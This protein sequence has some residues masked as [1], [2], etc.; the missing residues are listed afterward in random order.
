[1]SDAGIGVLGLVVLFGLIMIRIPV[2]IGLILVGVGGYALVDGWHVATIVAGEVPYELAAG[3]SLSV[4]PLFVLMGAVAARSNMAQELFDSAHALFSG[5]RGGLAMATVGACAAFGSICGSS[6]ATAA[7][8]TRVS[9]PEMLRHAYAN[10]LATG[11][12]VAGGTL[13]ILIPPSVILVIY[14]VIAEESVAALFAAALIPGLLLAAFQVLVVSAWCRIDRNVAPQ[15]DRLPWLARLRALGRAWK[16]LLLF[17]LSVG[18]IYLGLFSPTE[19]AAVGAGGAILIA[20]ATRAIDREGLV[21]AF[22]ETVTTTAMLFFIILGAT[23]FGRFIVL[24]QLPAA[25]T[26][27]VE[28]LALSPMLVIVVM[29][30]FYFLLGCFLESIS[31]LLITVPVFLP[32]AVAIGYDPVWF[33]VLVVIVVEVG[34]MT[35]PVGM[36]LFVVRAQMPDIPLSALYVGVMPFL[37]ANI[38]LI[39]VLLALPDVALWLPALLY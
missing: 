2:A 12:V 36:N 27:W 4:V 11:S 1:M 28:G 23:L 32:L 20:L 35:P 13:G 39:A 34:L 5:R 24:T 6:L 38:A 7:T 3:Y 30:A 21:S 31:M 37:L 16:L 18:G 26:G 8:M 17:G 19:A 29:V 22:V 10:T 15:S 33:G 9:V 14:A 25:L